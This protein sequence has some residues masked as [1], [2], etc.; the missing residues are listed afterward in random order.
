MKPLKEMITPQMVRW[1][2]IGIVFASISLGLIKVMVG[3]LAWPFALA[4]LLSSEIC[5]LLRFVAV[6]RWVFPHHHLTWRRLWRYHVVN[7]LGFAIWWGAANILKLVGVD[8]LLASA[9]AIFFSVGFSMVSNFY[10]VW[11]K[12]T[13]KTRPPHGH[14]KSPV[15][16]RR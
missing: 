9:L 15:A 4:T 1:I 7:A 5:T 6:N 3:T 16:T 14:V 2:A 8:Y 10:W 11:R 13:G 12:P